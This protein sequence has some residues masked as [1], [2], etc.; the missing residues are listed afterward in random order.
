MP[1][2][3]EEAVLAD[4][5]RRLSDRLRAGFPFSTAI[6]IADNASTDGTWPIAAAAGRT[7]CPSVRAVRL[8]QKGRGRALQAV[9][10]ASDAD[11]VAY[12]DVD[13]STDLDALLPLVAPLLSGHSRPGDR[14]PAGAR[15]R[16]SCAGPS[17]SSSPAPTTC[18]LR[19]ALRGAVLRRAVRLQ[20]DPRRRRPRAAAAGRG[21]RLV[22]RHRAAGARR[23]QRAAHPRGAGRLGRRPRLPRRHRRHRRST[24]CAASPASAAGSSPAASRC[25]TRGRSR[26]RSRPT[27]AESR[28]LLRS[29]CGSR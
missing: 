10:L 5:I 20:G 26:R 18:I 6:A 25:P 11:V 16:G 22:L 15:R 13:L 2:H 4:S 9:W 1:V 14:H 8:E 29:W 21:R 23:A 17:A 24:T 19:T 12:M 28:G 3:N 7:S 27:C